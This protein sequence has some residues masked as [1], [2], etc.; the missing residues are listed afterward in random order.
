VNLERTRNAVIL[1]TQPKLAGIYQISFMNILITGGAGFIGTHLSRHLLSLGHEL[2]VLDNFLP[3]VHAGNTELAPDISP[4]VRLVKGDV[5]DTNAFTSALLDAQCVVHLAAETGTGQSMYEVARYERTNLT[6]TAL[7]YDLIAKMPRHRVERVVV[8][9]SRSIYGEGAYRCDK[10]DVVYPVSRSSEDKQAG[11]YDPVCPK[12][13]GVCVTVATPE[14]APFQPS[15]F[16]GLTKQVQEQT[17]LLFGQ[18]LR[19]PSFALRFQNVYGP[20]QSLQNPYTGILAIFSNLAR[21]GRP[22]HVFED[23]RE[24][25]DFVYIDDVV[26][27]TAACVVGDAVGCHA[28]NVGSGE[29]TSVL[30]VAQGINEFYGGQ[31]AVETTGAFREGD[32]RHG[33]ADLTHARS[34]LG[35]NPRWGFRDG[36]QRFLQ[37]ANKS[38]PSSR[39]YEQSLAE[40][41]QRGL[42][43]GGA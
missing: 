25:R 7:L 36:L 20:G 26:W 35:Y 9:S 3:Q 31:S 18:V 24:S 39:G 19:I 27:A 21:T 30:D 37:W 2:T 11:N 43:H 22:I 8:A 33:M 4:H 38:A 17:V 14:S 34:L 42:L 5:A 16:Y 28:V 41:R 32:I 29:R 23:G 40:M 12:C 15:S 10:D 1:R 6:G 13:G